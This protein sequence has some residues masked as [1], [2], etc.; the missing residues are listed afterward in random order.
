MKKFKFKIDGSLYEVSVNE[1]EHN[2]A[3][4]EVNGTPFTVEIERQEKTSVASIN[5]KP[6]GKVTPIQTPSRNVVASAIKAPLPGSI[7]KVLVSAGQKVKRGDLLLTMESMKME[8]NI[9]AEHDGTIS[10]VHVQSGQ[11][12]MQ[13]DVLID[14]VG[15]E[16]EVAAPAPVSALVTEDQPLAA[17]VAKPSAGSKPVK[18]P[19][20]GNVLRVDVTA[21]QSVKRGD[22]LLVLESMKMEN[23]ILA[24][25]DAVVRNVHVKA[26]QTVMQDDV[27]FDL[28]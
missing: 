8:N 1:V 28:E 11:T 10:T 27:L 15:A 5:R 12:V 23:N 16:T 14:F 24:E 2:I 9:L 17:P 7:M 4:I 18:S 26:G 22:L 19:L 20:P 3:E 13:D 6:A 21:G 25:K